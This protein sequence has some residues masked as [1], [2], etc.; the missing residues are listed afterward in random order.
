MKSYEQTCG[1]AKALDLIGE[2]W[3][4][5]IIRD[6]MLGPMTYTEIQ[7]SLQ[8]IT[9]N[10][11]AKRLKELQ[12]N[13]IIEREK[14]VGR[15]P[16]YALSSSG[17]ELEKVLLAM[18]AWGWQYLDPKNLP[19]YK[20][21]RWAMFSLRRRLKPIGRDW[22]LR[23]DSDKGS[24]GVWERSGRI[25]T[26]KVSDEH[27]CEVLVEGSQLLLLKALASLKFSES[28]GIKIRGDRDLLEKVFANQNPR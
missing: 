11:L 1:I 6:L 10:L 17:K 18:G 8:G 14:K 7:D 25:E 24:Y 26:A 3:T 4:I 13:Q 9:T 12:Q 22:T 2:R 16:S 23:L 5:L 19:Q 27:P 20:S 15:H 28:L 21:L